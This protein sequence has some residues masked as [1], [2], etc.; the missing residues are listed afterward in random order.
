M[1]RLFRLALWLTLAFSA[2]EGY[3]QRLVEVSGRVAPGEVRVFLRD[4]LYRVNGT[5]TIGGTLIIEPGTTVEF[6]DNGRMIDSTGGRIIADGRMSVTYNNVNFA[7]VDLDPAIAGIQRPY[8]FA[9]PAFFL[10]PGVFTISTPNEVTVAGNRNTAV[11]GKNNFV[12]N[13]VLDTTLAAGQIGGTA[14]SRN[15]RLINLSNPTGAVAAP[16]FIQTPEAAL[17]YE[18]ARLRFANADPNINI[19][20]FRRAFNPANPTGSVNVNP[21]TITFRGRRV[22]AFSREWGHIVVLP[23]ARAAFFR[24]VNFQDFRKDTLVDRFPYYVTGGTAAARGAVNNELVSRSNGGGGALTS[25]SSRTWLVNCNFTNN[26][27]RLRGGALQLLEAPTGTGF[28]P[29]VAAANAALPAYANTSN[30]GITENSTGAAVNQTVRAIDNLATA[31][32]EPFTD[33]ERQG[34]DD[35]R[36][37][38]Y[39][40]R[41]RQLNFDGNR[42]LNAN[43]RQITTGGVTILTDDVNN[44]ANFITSGFAPARKNQAFGGAMFIA[45]L[46]A[47]NGGDPM[48]VGFGINDEINGVSTGS[49][50]YINFSGNSASNL[51]NNPG[52]L[53]ARGGAVYIGDQTSVTFAGSFTSNQATVPFISNIATDAVNSL[54]YSMGGAIYVD[55]SAGRL[56]VRGGQILDARFPSHYR[57]NSA[58]RGGAIFVGNSLFLSEVRPS[59]IIGGSDALILT[60]NYGYNIV[61][62][63]NNA[64][65][66]GG[67]VYAQKNMTVY[68]AGGVAGDLVL[69]YSRPFRVEFTRNTAGYSGG[70]MTINLDPSLPLSR[71]YVQVVR[72][73]LDS[74]AVGVGSVIDTDAG[75]RALVRGGGAIYSLN[76]NLNV[77]KGVEFVMNT[78][79]YGNGGAIA[80]VSPGADS[81]R[82]MITDLDQLTTAPGSGE[83]VAFTSSNEVFTN[84]ASAITPPDARMLTRFIDNEAIANPAQQGNG[85]TQIGEV[86]RFHPGVALPENGTGLG[87]AI[88]ILDSASVDLIGRA[89]S[90]S[91]NRVRIQN[92]SAFS[93]AA[94][95]SDNYDLKLIFLRS[96]ITGNTATS[97]IGRNQNA[98][99][100]PFIRT[101]GENPASSDLASAVLYGE[102][103][104]PL[105]FAAPSIGANSIYDNDGRFL[106]R[107]PDA[108]NTKGSS[109]LGTVGRGG[110]D[111]L[112]GNY[113]GRT[114]APVTTILPES[115]TLQETF[116]V[117][118]DGTTHLR[119]IRN[120]NNPKEQGPFES[121]ER[122]NY[123]PIPV[124]NGADQNTV[125]ANS[126]PERLLM[127]GRVYDLFDKGT[128]I[129]TADYSRRRMSPIEDF[130]VGIPKNIRRFTNTAGAPS[131]NRYVRRMGR[132]P[133]VAEVDANINALQTEFRGDQPIGY[134][135]FLEARANYTGTAEVTNQDHPNAPTINETVFFVINE[136]TGDFVR[137]NLRQVNT[138]SEIF[139]GR[140]EMLPDSS[141]RA[142]N[143]TGRR[144]AEGLANFGSGR[145]LL[146]Q[147]ARNGFNE[148]AAALEGRRYEEGSNVL[149]TPND[150][151]VQFSNRPRLPISN[152]D[153]S[154]INPNEVNR[155]NFWAGE[156]YR[157]LPVANGD[158]VRVVSRTVLWNEGVN[159]AYDD[160][161]VF[162]VGVSTP[163]PVFTGNV[164]NLRN[165]L[166]VEL[167]NMI[168]VSEDRTYP[169]DI[170]DTDRAPGR[171]SI[172]TISGV[173]SNIFY[174]PRSVL[175]P[176]DFTQL[177]YTYSVEP[178]SGLSYWLE[179]DTI[180]SDQPAVS[181]ARGYVVLGGRPTNPFVVPGGEVV[182]VG[183][184]NFPPNA[185]TLDSLRS[186]G[187]ADS[188]LARY[189]N[190]FPPYFH[191]EAYDVVNAR[192][193]QQDTINIGGNSTAT[194]QF[195]IFVTDTNPVFTSNIY[196]CGTDELLVANLTDRLRFKLDLQTDDEAE[197]AAAAARGWDFRYGKTAYGFQS[198][199]V[200]RNPNDSVADEVTLVRPRWMSNEYFVRYNAFGSADPLGSDFTSA[201][202]L[203]IRVDSAQAYNLLRPVRQFENALNVDTTV[204]FVV[205]DGHGRINTLTRRVMVNV[206]PRIE[207]TQLPAAFEDQDYNTALLD[208][209]R[210]IRVVDPNFGQAQNFK[211][212]YAS[213]TNTFISRDLCFAD[214][215]GS[216]DVRNLKTAPNWLRIDPVSG[217][218][219]GTPRVTD[220]PFNDTTISL[221]VVVTDEGGLTDVRTFTMR[222]VS[223][224]HPPVL[225][226]L[227]AVR[228]VELGKAYTDTII[229]SDID[230]R[231]LGATTERVT[232]TAGNGLTVT[233]GVINGTLASDTVKLVVNTSNFQ[234]Q[235]G[236]LDDQGK[237][238]VTITATDRA[239]ASRT[240][241]YKVNVSQPTDFVVPMRISNTV[242][243]RESAFQ[244]M[245]WGTGVN[246]T[247]GEAN[248][249][250]GKLDSNYC[251]YEL[252]P[253]P[254]EDVYDARWT[255]PS[256]NGTLRNIFPRA[257]PGVAG[258]AT[259]KGRFQGGDVVGN[260]SSNYPIVI[261]W[262]KND[263]PARTDAVRNPAGSSWWMLDAS[264]QGNLFAVNM[265]TG[266]SRSIEDVQVAVQ[267]DTIVM[268][269][270]R[271]FIQN[272]VI[273]Y[274][275][276]SDVAEEAPVAGANFELLQNTP[277]P[278]SGNTQIGF[279]MPNDGNV[280]IE[281]FDA[282]GNK[283]A[284]FSGFYPAGKREVTW[285]G[286]SANGDALSA[287]MYVV[288]LSS[289]TVNITRQMILVR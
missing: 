111:T 83:A 189:I 289:G 140:I 38:V 24:D 39:L 270:K 15:R 33:T 68:G 245:E 50:D 185:N 2:Y 249:A 167:R 148:D 71:R 193:L 157:A 199:A 203:N 261:K 192:Y 107:L 113:W 179:S 117:A 81:R 246:A 164:N 146:A 182:T 4:S 150:F 82:F 34:V 109:S 230:L 28:F 162:N 221:T 187:I 242:G 52:T 214:E 76:A 161:L 29:D 202:Q 264:S 142:G 218:L 122:F 132:D 129:K 119:Y 263:V 13:V 285:N 73:I 256:S 32:A 155:V 165:L 63:R 141:N 101:T 118:G 186:S 5:Y 56:Q 253:I 279:V 262:N 42:V 87:G 225:A 219:F 27:A 136:T 147:L 277:N 227:P 94:V 64:I 229:V 138:S 154:Q 174:D 23:G 223:V 104:G 266:A 286:T 51:Q 75:S 196:T 12:Y 205:N 254:P 84:A 70:A 201:G 137:A 237:A 160:A 204:T 66:H 8:G 53:G 22:N 274:D 93:G 268:T 239:G 209:M 106:I 271:D 169:R 79:N 16:Q 251:E 212:L 47:A 120:S 234:A 3:G 20:P 18:A 85:T 224:N 54:G 195:R 188:I 278:F 197:D 198:I 98:I 232:I 178:G 44:P 152:D 282:L 11:S 220:V 180:T 131:F 173:D 233:P 57:N 21:A 95:Y 247:T 25:F 123:T 89:D 273:V 65:F 105:P 226:A 74:N 36:L 110:V 127:Q 149:G 103:V 6:T 45:G 243:G 48:E 200:R 26:F 159:A 166:P 151:G 128:D 37:A 238:T 280:E 55:A 244:I 41:V 77:V 215:A 92:N 252:P 62:D 284:D 240:I 222:V 139:R 235:P 90:V 184:R 145:E 99:T 191:A 58:S 207:N 126:I 172:F 19:Q 231:R 288:R 46:G 206:S 190:T 31:T 248:N 267:G 216:F 211:L 265:N 276:T 67:A 108:P 97:D 176:G 144:S 241:R 61:F 115:G 260:T 269:I 181:G 102:I 272:F 258:Q 78:A 72:A 91:F 275:F 143:T 283:V 60:R 158:L 125:G 124:A 281:I 9:D 171:D 1:Q 7:N 114:E 287:G 96:L 133:F 228:C 100:G 170:N 135:L 213:D 112:R 80:L 217:I 49:K 183:I 10:A 130:A 259:Y 59:P 168:F 163:P 134:P 43:I 30:S 156:R 255:V 86:T 69:G 250:L 177:T 14:N 88:Y 208:S 35:A 121:Q 17:I 175:A 210:R 257:V 236:D 116:F 153:N 40:G 194:Y